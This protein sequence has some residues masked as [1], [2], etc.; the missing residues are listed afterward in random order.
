MDMDKDVKKILV[1]DDNSINLKLADMLLRSRAGWKPVP[2]PSGKRAMMFLERNKAD[3]ILLDFMMPEEDGF[4]VLA[5]LRANPAT[6]DIPVVFLTGVE[7]AQTIE[8]I[9]A[10]GIEDIVAKPFQPEDLLAVAAKY[11]D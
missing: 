5:K 10:Q 4:Q 7:D 2:V 9:K 6:A 3:L 1:I 11:L 8:S